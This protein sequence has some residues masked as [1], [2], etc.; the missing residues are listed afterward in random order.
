MM[1]RWCS[2]FMIFLLLL[3]VLLLSVVFSN[4]LPLEGFIGYNSNSPN[5]S[6]VLVKPYSS[7]IQLLKIYDSVYYDSTSGNVLELFG[8]PMGT[9]TGATSD[10]SSLTDMIV[11]PR[12]GSDI[13]IYSRK[14]T[15]PPD[16]TFSENTVES[17]YLIPIQSSYEAWVYP[18]VGSV[19]SHAFNYQ[20]F[21][22]PWKTQTVMVINDILQTKIIGAFPIT[23][24]KTTSM[25]TGNTVY[26]RT[27][28]S[29]LHVTDETYVDVIPQYSVP[30]G[31]KNPTQLYKIESNIWFD[32]SNG[33]I[34]M[35]KT[36]ST[37]VTMETGISFTMNMETDTSVMKSILFNDPE[38]QYILI[39]TAFPQNRTMVSILCLDEKN[40]SSTQLLSI[41]KVILFDPSL[42]GGIDTTSSINIKNH[43]HTHTMSPTNVPERHEG[44][45]GKDG[46]DGKEY[47]F[48]LRL[49]DPDM[50]QYILKSQIVPPVCPAC[51]S[52][53]NNSCASC[54]AVTTMAPIIGGSGSNSLSSLIAN[55]YTVG[56]NQP[57][58]NV[59]GPNWAEATTTMVTGAEGTVG[60]VLDTAIGG[61][62]L[63]G[64]G[65]I[66]GVTSL[67]TAVADD[68]TK[69][70]TG[71]VG[72]V[73]DVA[74]NIV[75]SV[76]DIINNAMD[77]LTNRQNIPEG[78]AAYDSTQGETG[79]T[80]EDEEEQ[81][82]KKRAKSRHTSTPTPV[83]A[84]CTAANLPGEYKMAT[85][86]GLNNYYGALANRNASNFMPVTSDFS[87]FGR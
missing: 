73:A 49:P 25:N 53:N 80:N 32:T 28:A 78:T 55:S 34:I 8:T 86:P 21:Y 67:G 56:Q 54:Q 47:T 70:G 16:P 42:P 85:G 2:P 50:N 3:I 87:K 60:N 82:C 24:A 26:P 40:S 51:P 79:Y 35:M 14:R 6:H 20:I 41:Y 17:K 29:T 58:E 84:A 5:E 33:I 61:T 57:T 52:C 37:D 65:A 45:D 38:N 74:D 44:R 43:E 72:D 46:K 69:L 76:K 63:L 11:I 81:K 12:L 4:Y 48:G 36:G 30:S 71:V 10:A 7:T 31:L 66:G 15:T 64:L 77:D 9:G 27:A 83:G 23:S 75:S 22:F 39:C 13:I 18:N 59:S 68:V 62:A 1:K 19:S